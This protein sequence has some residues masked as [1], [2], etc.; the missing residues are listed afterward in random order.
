MT[1]E[2]YKVKS[3]ESLSVIARDLLNDIDRWPEIAFLNNIRHPYFIYPG[4]VLELPPENGSDIIEV[5]S[6]AVAPI[7]QKAN[8]P[9]RPATLVLLVVGA[10]LFFNR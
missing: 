1:T 8:V 3:G 2:I 7:T 4:Q 5:E 6:T 9:L 10:A